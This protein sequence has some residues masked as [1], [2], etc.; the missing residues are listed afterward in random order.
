LIRYSLSS[1]VLQTILA[2]MSN[3][4]SLREN[5]CFG[6]TNFTQAPALTTLTRL[7]DIVDVDE[8]NSLLQEWTKS[9]YLKLGIDI[10]K[11]NHV[12]IDGKILRNYTDSQFG[13]KEENAITLVTAFCTDLRLSLESIVF[14]SKCNSESKAFRELIEKTSQD[15]CIGLITGDALHV[16]ESTL[17]LLKKKKLDYLLTVKTNCP[18]LLKELE[19]QKTLVSGSVFKV[20]NTI[21]KIVKVYSIDSNFKTNPVSKVFDW[22][23]MNINSYI[24]VT[25]I[26]KRKRK[27]TRKQLMRI[28][29]CRTTGKNKS[30]KYKKDQF[31]EFYSKQYI[32]SKLA[33]DHT[34]KEF[35]QMIRDHWSIENHLHRARDVV[36]SEDYKKSKSSVLI[37]NT[38]TILTTVMNIFSIHQYKSMK[39]IVK[40]ATNR[41]DFCLDLL[42]A[43][44]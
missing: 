32:S 43:E 28:E 22:Y 27:L 17:S 8:L 30:S 44:R 10:S 33:K 31:K 15:I 29:Y 3:C 18:L 38:S 11:V 26:D 41:I 6:I 1:I 37:K 20:S 24:T 14:D 21:T 42:G 23:D 16:S 9:I 39:Q 34:P 19:L 4:I 2:Y 12:S 36:F 35:E 25:T 40:Y 13:S 7:L 5:T